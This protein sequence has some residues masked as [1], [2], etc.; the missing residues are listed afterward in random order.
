MKKFQLSTTGSRVQ[1]KNEFHNS[2]L[3]TVS[4][5]PDEWIAE[6]ERIR[7]LIKATGSEI[8]DEDLIIHIMNNLPKDM[9][10]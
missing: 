1:Y 6:L 9:K 3:S 7:K 2:R 5:D 8:T 4:N 10:H